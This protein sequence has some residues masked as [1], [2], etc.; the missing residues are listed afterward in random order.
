MNSNFK[1]IVHNAE[2]NTLLSDDLFWVPL[3]NLGKS[4]YCNNYFENFSEMDPYCVKKKINNCYEAAQYLHSINFREEFNGSFIKEKGI[5]WVE[6]SSGYKTLV[7]KFGVCISIASAFKFLIED[8]YEKIGYIFFFRPDTSG[9]ALLYICLNNSYYIIDPSALAYG[10]AEN[11]VK[12]SGNKA[13]FKDK[14]ITSICYKTKDLLKFV[15][16]Y[17]KHLLYK[18]IR[19]LYIDFLCSDEIAR[20]GIEKTDETVNIYLPKNTKFKILRNDNE[21][22]Y[23]I[24]LVSVK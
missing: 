11:L 22:L 1:N 9:H 4:R 14:I 24:N 7:D 20:M 13:D 15:S 21:D 10:S 19:F 18:D 3:N 6:H 5:N 8:C 2:F 16:Y 12:E 23:K 17:R